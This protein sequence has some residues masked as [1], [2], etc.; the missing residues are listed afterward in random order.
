[1]S[2]STNIGKQKFEVLQFNR[3]HFK[4]INNKFL[5]KKSYQD[6]RKND[7]NSLHGVIILVRPFFLASL[8]PKISRLHLFSHECTGL[9]NSIQN[10]I[11]VPQILLHYLFIS[12]LFY[13]KP[14]K[15]RLLLVKNLNLSF[16]EKQKSHNTQ[17]ILIRIYHKEI[18]RK[19]KPAL[20]YCSN[21]RL[22]V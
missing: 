3:R 6:Q 10:F 14:R 11:L 2:K 15:H 18:P 22:N 7:E 16:Y 19:I 12:S 21:L 4:T 20:F 13:T 9:L 1:M 17:N 8:A 5:I